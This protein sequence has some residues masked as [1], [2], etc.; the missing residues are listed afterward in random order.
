M[1]KFFTICSLVVLA[2]S[3]S[4]NAGEVTIKG[5]HLCC[6]GCLS[7]AKDAFDDVRGITKI[8]CDLNTKVVKF[9]ATDEKTANQGIKALSAAGFFGTATHEKKKLKFPDAGGKKKQKLD[10]FVLKGVHLCCGSC[11]TMSQKS[12][13][14]VSGVKVIDIDRKKKTIKLTGSSIEVKAAITA[15]NKAGFYGKLDTKPA[16]PA[17]KP[18]PKPKTK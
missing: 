11:V 13:Q 7:A 8:S 5:V 18:T 12:L 3:V 1:R 9:N 4:V 6:G 14:K 17:K 10:T 15:L 2:S 16:K